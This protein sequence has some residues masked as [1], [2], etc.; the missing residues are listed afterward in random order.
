[1]CH[2]KGDASTSSRH[3]K[4][5]HDCPFPGTISRDP[6]GGRGACDPGFLRLCTAVRGSQSRDERSECPQGHEVPLTVSLAVLPRGHAAAVGQ[7]GLTERSEGGSDPAC[8]TRT[9]TKSPEDGAEGS[10]CLAA[11]SA[12]SED[13]RRRRSISGGRR[14]RFNPRHAP[15]VFTAPT[16]G[17]HRYRTGSLSAGSGCLDISTSR[18]ASPSRYPVSHHEL[19]TR[20]GA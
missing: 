20:P 10:F 19:G 14:L 17:R 5:F 3:D 12:A 15:T 18:L 8:P 7:A 16:T 11:A 2:G 6:E 13:H 1:M 4:A 9:A